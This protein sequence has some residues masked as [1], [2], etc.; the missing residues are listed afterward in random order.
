MPGIVQAE[1]RCPVGDFLPPQAG[2]LWVLDVVV[3]GSW[4][5]YHLANRAWPKPKGMPVI[6]VNSINRWYNI[7]ESGK[8]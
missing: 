6:W 1:Q 5:R 8:N 2:F 3:I 4:Y 7:G